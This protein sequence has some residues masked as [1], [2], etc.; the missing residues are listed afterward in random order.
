M[1]RKIGAKIA[2]LCLAAAMAVSFAGCGSDTAET[3]MQPAEIMAQVR[4]T[5]NTVENVSLSMN[6][7]VDLTNRM[8]E[9]ASQIQAKIDLDATIRQNPLQMYAAVDVSANGDGSLANLETASAALYLLP[10]GDNYTGYVGQGE[11][12]SQM[13]WQKETMSA[14]D[15]AELQE[16]LSSQKDS[17]DLKAMEKVSEAL[18]DTMSLEITG[19]E[20]VGSVDALV[21]SGEL[22]LGEAISIL[23]TCGIDQLESSMKNIPDETLTMLNDVT[24]PLQFYID[25]SQNMLVKVTMDFKTTIQQ[26]IKQAILS[27]AGTSSTT[28]DDDE[29]MDLIPIDINAA[30]ISITINAINDDVPEIEVPQ[31]VIDQVVENE[32]GENETFSFSLL[33]DLT[34]I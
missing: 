33:G 16:Q 2:A 22:Q 4:E 9:E 23:Q 7:N 21:I 13:E 8:E 11:S 32:D 31:T 3:T 1:K 14:D 5:M 30:E 34:N 28:I 29:L 18:Q 20:R 24:V 27:Y 26:I 17:D 15:V 19:R 6:L 12:S 25:D 10:D